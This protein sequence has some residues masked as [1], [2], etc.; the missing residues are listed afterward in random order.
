[1]M[2]TTTRAL[3]TTSMLALTT[4]CV[5]MPSQ[6]VLA[7][8]EGDQIVNEQRPEHDLPTRAAE[9]EG[10]AEEPEAR[11]AQ[12]DLRDHNRVTGIKAQSGGTCW[13]HGTMA[14]I[15]SHLLSSG[16]WQ[17]LGYE[18]E[19]NFSE[20]HLD[21]WN[22][23]NKFRNSDVGDDPDA[24]GMTVHQGGDYRVA[25]AYIARGDGVVFAP[26]ANDD[27]YKDKL[28]YD[29]APNRR[30][31][32]Y[33]KFYI[34]HI[35]WYTAGDGVERINKIKD[36]IREHGAVATCYCAGSRFLS[37]DNVHYQP[38]S[39]DRN[40]NHSVAI[41]GWDDSKIASTAKNRAPL[42]GAWLIKNSWGDQRG[43]D[44]YYWISYFDKHA[45]Q[46][47]ELGAVS[48]RDAEPLKYDQFYSHDYHGWRGTMMILSGIMGH[49]AVVGAVLRPVDFDPEFS[50]DDPE[51]LPF[52]S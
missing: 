14:S 46:H 3:G 10:Q 16:L 13:A 27:N 28:W 8:D 40:P 32:G 1:M 48:F 2:N 12:Y 49:F 9:G 15:E 39:S 44:G 6:A 47:I 24:P 19:P 4:L 17:S 41:V 52:V 50:Y 5:L 36:A 43:E 34:R 23:F 26:M 20:Y 22:G 29:E 42:P 35:E 7:Q 31:P 38:P 45:C 33:E 25:A 11:P 51:G 30:A 18:E 21:W 37:E